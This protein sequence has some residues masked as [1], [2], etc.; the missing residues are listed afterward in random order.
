MKRRKECGA[1]E[2]TDPLRP[3]GIAYI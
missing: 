2:R 1:F 3:W